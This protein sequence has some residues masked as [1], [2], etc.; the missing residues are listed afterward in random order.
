MSLS[1]HIVAFTGHRHYDHSSDESLWGVVTRLYDEGCRIFR[2][3]MAEGFDLAAGEAVL[4]LKAAHEDVM[5]EAIIPYPDFKNHFGMVDRSRYY[6]IAER[7]DKLC[8][9]ATNYH[10]GVYRQRNDLLV[11]GA[12]CVVAW[13]DGSPSGTRYTINRAR[14]QHSHII[15]LYPRRQLELWK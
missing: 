10:V 12:G 14:R 15:N 13:Y 9:T 3:G 8:Y 7:A 11:E 5:L 1:P 4:R 2:T 6:H